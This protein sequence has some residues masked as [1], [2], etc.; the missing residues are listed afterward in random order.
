MAIS[1]SQTVTGSA[2]SGNTVTLTSWSPSSW[3]LILLAVACRDDGSGLVTGVSGNGLIWSLVRSIA[4]DDNESRLRIYRAQGSAP[5]TGSIVVTLSGNTSPVMCVA[6]RFAGC[7]TSGL[8]G[9]AAVET[10]TYDNGPSGSNDDMLKSVTTISTNAWAVA[11]GTHRNTTFTP[12]AGETSISINNS[13]GS[14]SE[15]VTVSEWYE[16]ATSPATVQLGVANDLSASTDWVIIVVSL[17]PSLIE[18]SAVQAVNY[19]KHKDRLRKLIFKTAAGDVICTP[20]GWVHPLTSEY[21][22]NEVQGIQVR[23]TLR[24]IVPRDLRGSVA[25]GDYCWLTPVDSYLVTSVKS[26]EHATEMVATIEQQVAAAEPDVVKVVDL[27]A[28]TAETVVWQ[29]VTGK[30]FR[31]IQVDLSVSGGAA[32]KLVFRDGLAGRI[33]LVGSTSTIYSSGNLGAGVLSSTV[34]NPLTLERD[35][36]VTAQGHILGFEE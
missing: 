33:V 11:F 19:R 34:D 18:V 4:N 14:G 20:F 31:L 24:I 8:N 2:A 27:S 15:T 29:P 28:A 9:S 17:K 12:D 25:K 3:D 13:V 32:V 16:A 21:A 26:F 22:G 7:D 6:T 30:R 35:S 10:S 5:T 23:D 1:V 36:A